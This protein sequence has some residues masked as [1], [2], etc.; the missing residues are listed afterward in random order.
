MKQVIYGRD[1]CWESFTDM[2]KNKLS[3]SF[4]SKGEQ[5]GPEDIEVRRVLQMHHRNCVSLD[6]LVAQ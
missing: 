1:N 6:P 3:V 5:G 4:G 2:E